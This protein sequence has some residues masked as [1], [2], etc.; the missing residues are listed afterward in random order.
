MSAE[1]AARVM[2]WEAVLRLGETSM[3]TTEKCLK[4]GLVWHSR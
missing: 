1:E 2:C 3:R 4:T